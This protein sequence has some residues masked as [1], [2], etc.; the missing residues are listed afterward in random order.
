VRT[1]TLVTGVFTE[2]KEVLDIQVPRLKVRAHRAFALAALIHSDSGII[3][4]FEE[5][6]NSLAAPV[7]PLDAGT[8]RAHTRPV[9]T[10]SARPLRKLR[11]ISD[12]LKY[13]LKIVRDRCEIAGTKLWMQCSSVEEGWRA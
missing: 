5:G 1:T 8:G 12:T 10:K 9:V 13:V 7:R 6:D 2:L 4:D 3:R 11:V